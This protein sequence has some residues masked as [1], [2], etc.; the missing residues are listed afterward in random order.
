MRVGK[1]QHSF[2]FQQI[3][4]H[5]TYIGDFLAAVDD[6]GASARSILVLNPSEWKKAIF[7]LAGAVLGLASKSRTRNREGHPY[8]ILATR[9]R[10]RRICI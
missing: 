5:A 9:A 2:D 3:V 7:A 1:L 10:Y 6:Y 4:I 8:V